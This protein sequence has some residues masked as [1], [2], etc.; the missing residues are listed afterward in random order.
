[1]PGPLL[2][3]HCAAF[4]FGRADNWRFYWVDGYPTPLAPTL[5]KRL[6][7]GNSLGCR[8]PACRDPVT[9]LF[10][11]WS[12]PKCPCMHPYDGLFRCMV[13]FKFLVTGRLIRAAIRHVIATCGLIFCLPCGPGDV[14]VVHAVVRFRCCVRLLPLRLLP[15]PWALRGCSVC[16]RA[17]AFASQN[18]SF[19]FLHFLC[20]CPQLLLPP[21]R[22]EHA[23]STVHQ[24]GGPKPAMN[25]P[26]LSGQVMRGAL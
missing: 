23:C 19:R 10:G 4:R 16:S 25:N 14:H 9:P 26:H 22:E 21:V 5:G 18:V 13:H 20:Q 6:G 11:W 24:H 1:M 8:F 15:R 12:R 17:C 3:G 7:F 2:P